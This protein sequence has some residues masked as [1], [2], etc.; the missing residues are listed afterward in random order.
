MNELDEFAIILVL[1]L[2]AMI[3]GQFALFFVIMILWGIVDGI[4]Y[5]LMNQE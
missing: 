4:I 1:A 2:L 3:T 5:G